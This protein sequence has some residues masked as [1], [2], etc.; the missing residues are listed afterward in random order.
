[1]I[2]TTAKSAD[3]LKI[4]EFDADVIVHN[5]FVKDNMPFRENQP[6]V[7]TSTSENYAGPP[8][9]GAFADETNG[10]EGT[11]W[12]A[13]DQASGG[14][15]LH[16]NPS[17]GSTGMDLSGLFMFKKENFLRGHRR[18][19]LVKMD[20]RSSVSVMLDAVDALT[21]TLFF[22]FKD[23]TGNF[24]ISEPIDTHANMPGIPVNFEPTTLKYYDFLPLGGTNE[25]VGRVKGV[26]EPSFE[27]VEWI[28]YRLDASRGQDSYKPTDV[29]VKVF[30]VHATVDT[31]QPKSPP[32]PNSKSTESKR[33]NLRKNPK[34]SS[35]STSSS[36][37]SSSSSNDN[38]QL[39]DDYLQYM[40]EH[41][42]SQ[43]GN[44][45]ASS[46]EQSS[47]EYYKYMMGQ[48]GNSAAL[49]LDV[50]VNAVIRIDEHPHQYFGSGSFVEFEEMEGFGASAIFNVSALLQHQN[51][52]EI[53][54]LLFKDLGLDIVRLRNSF[55]IDSDDEH[56][57]YETMIQNS[58]TFFEM[59]EKSLGRPLKSLMTS[60]TPPSDIKTSGSPNGGTLSYDVENFDDYYYRPFAIWWANSLE[61]Y[62]TMGV[63]PDFVSIQN[64][65]NIDDPNCHS[66]NLHAFP[67]G[68]NS[69][70]GYNMALEH[71]LQWLELEGEN[72]TKVPKYVGPERR[73]FGTGSDTDIE[74]Y[75]TN[76]IKPSNVWAWAHKVVS[77]E[78][79]LNPD[80]LNEEFRDF[81][82]HNGGKP[83]FQTGYQPD[84]TVRELSPIKRILHLAKF[85]HNSVTV[86]RVAA[87][88]YEN[89][90]S[91]NGSGLID[92]P[93][94][95]SY[96]VSPE[97][98][99]FKHFSAHIRKEMTQ[100]ETSSQEH[101][102]F[103]S[104]YSNEDMLM[105]VVIINENSDPVSLNIDFEDLTVTGGQVY[106]T[107]SDSYYKMV[108]DFQLNTL[109]N[110]EGQ[111]VTTLALTYLSPYQF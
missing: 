58:V 9:Y 24:H 73:G 50:D 94:E 10:D 15:K 47:D 11:L 52:R 48:E 36:S 8:I 45:L 4:L 93:D 102:V 104:A 30:T 14:L 103:L 18:N 51:A 68:D 78:V 37:S 106:Q 62:R 74:I 88:F 26:S 35:S 64:E 110:L 1:V 100:L 111:S 33:S 17:H 2:A 72:I 39:S 70:A 44:S 27:G 49:S 95:I 40:N 3:R 99:A 105:V 5:V 107:T 97:Y 98:Y 84:S 34:S 83:I 54:D 89:L 92:I 53:T 25:E 81:Y 86:E 87:F 32:T 90:F 12:A 21:A 28:G 80:N 71:M 43:E 42:M 16:W 79:G 6:L 22:V 63:E 55:L 82:G 67:T 85:I 65:P 7:S 13:T 69:V 56:L 76:I 23:D 41:D 77:E 66:L 61:H 19:A 108:G 20:E 60:Y 75:I 29:G 31:T 59:A 38:E 96:N 109:L 91:T 101:G 57:P 46:I